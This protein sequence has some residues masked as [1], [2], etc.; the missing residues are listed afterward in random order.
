MRATCPAHL[1]LLDLTTLI[2]VGEVYRSRVR[3]DIPP[4]PNTPTGRGSK[5]KNKENFTFTLP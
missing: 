1:V 2:I 5:L 3:G 4:I